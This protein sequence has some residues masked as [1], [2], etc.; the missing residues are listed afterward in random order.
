VARGFKKKLEPGTYNLKVTIKHTMDVS[1][2]D[3]Y[4][5]EDELLGLCRRN[6]EMVD[7]EVE[8]G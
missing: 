8:R 5:D 4:S 1:E 6:G 7:W 3:S 2:E